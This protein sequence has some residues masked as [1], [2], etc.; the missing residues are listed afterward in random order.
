VSKPTAGPTPL[1][2]SS[3]WRGSDGVFAHWESPAGTG[4]GPGRFGLGIHGFHVDNEHGVPHPHAAATRYAFFSA[5]DHSKA[6]AKK[7]GGARKSHK[8]QSGHELNVFGAF[9]TAWNGKPLEE[10]WDAAQPA[11]RKKNKSRT[12]YPGT[13][14]MRDFAK[15]GGKGITTMDV[16]GL[17]DMLIKLGH[18]GQKEPHSISRLNLF[19]HAD[20]DGTIWL[21]GEVTLNNVLFYGYRDSLSDLALDEY[22]D[23]NKETRTFGRG[24]KDKKPIRLADVRRAFGEGAHLVVYACHSGVNKPYLKKVRELFGVKVVEGF[25]KMIRYDFDV[26][27]GG[28]TNSRFA[29]EY[30]QDSVSD[31]HRLT[32][33]IHEP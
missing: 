4:A 20:G 7:A 8:A 19:T 28:L 26:M 3:L 18:I 30:S 21:K 23:E 22:L 33:N 32:P 29:I 31:Y 2:G 27:K 5:G 10:V 1:H 16:G 9:P 11:D 14:D 6:V 15:N 17:E 25:S 13:A 24:P 12:W